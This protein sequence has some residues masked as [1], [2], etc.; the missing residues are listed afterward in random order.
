MTE[1]KTVPAQHP[2]LKVVC[3][4]DTSE[5]AP[6][7]GASYLHCAKCLDEWQESFRGVVSPRDYARQQVALTREG[8]QVWCTRHDANIT[9][10]RYRAERV[11]KERKR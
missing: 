3:Y 5:T 6:D 2:A 4:H 8:V 7:E 1:D 10:M 11:R 9:H